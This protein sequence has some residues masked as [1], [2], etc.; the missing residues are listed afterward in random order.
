LRGNK[1]QAQSERESGKGQKLLFHLDG[2]FGRWI[3]ILWK[4]L[5]FY[6]CAGVVFLF[7]PGLSNCAKLPFASPC[8][9]SER[10]PF[11]STGDFRPQSFRGSVRER[12][13]AATG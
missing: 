5:K 4:R 7:S 6:V 1:A 12:R 13:F 2:L 9:A 10:A 3:K 8:V 11:R